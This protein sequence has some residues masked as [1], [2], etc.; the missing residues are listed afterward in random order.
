MKKYSLKKSK[1]F[2]FAAI[3]LVLSSGAYGFSFSSMFHSSSHPHKAAA[4]APTV[5][6]S[7]SRRLMANYCGVESTDY[8]F[9]ITCDYPDKIASFAASESAPEKCKQ[10]NQGMDGAIYPDKV[11]LPVDFIK[12]I[13]LC[14]NANIIG[15]NTF[16]TISIQQSSDQ[17]LTQNSHTKTYYDIVCNPQASFSPDI[18]T[19][20]QQSYEQSLS[21]KTAQCINVVESKNHNIIFMIIKILLGMGFL[22][23]FF[24]YY[25]KI[26]NKILQLFGKK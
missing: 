17:Q 16:Y 6:Y 2:D 18:Y 9:K 12:S 21:V 25:G 14:P 26:K 22:T 8:G 24:M 23:V 15:P 5:D 1:L 20:Q 3:S 13:N 11:A 7:E 19:T 4:A 10:I